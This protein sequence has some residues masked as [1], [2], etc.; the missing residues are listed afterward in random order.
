MDNITVSPFTVADAYR[1]GQNDGFKA[2]IITGA[3]VVVLLKA[4]FDNR[5]Q[6]KYWVRKNE[7]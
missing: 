3:V 6:R 5:K 4:A 2:G 7:K 1:V